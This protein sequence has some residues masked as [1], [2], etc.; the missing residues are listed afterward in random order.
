[1]KQTVISV[2]QRHLPVRRLIGSK[3]ISISAGR[4]NTESLSES[5]KFVR[6]NR[7]Q[8]TTRDFSPDRQ[9]SSTR[10]RPDGGRSSS[11]AREKAPPG[12]GLKYYEIQPLNP[13]QN[14]PPP[15]LRLISSTILEPL[16]NDGGSTNAGTSPTYTLISCILLT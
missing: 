6:E 15:D 12:Q 8:P 7:N 11:F 5:Y 10:E 2:R 3:T 4:R 1:L 13:D 9:V 16:G 14:P